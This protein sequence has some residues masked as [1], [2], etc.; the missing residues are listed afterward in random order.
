MMPS[1]NTEKLESAPPVKRSSI[2]SDTFE[3][4]KASANARNGMPGTGTNAPKR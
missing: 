1:E 2:V 3:S 4:W